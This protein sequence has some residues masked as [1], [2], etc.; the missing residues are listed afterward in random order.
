MDATRDYHIKWSQKENTIPYHSSMES[1]IQHQWTCLQNKNRLTDI[2]IELVVARAACCAWRP[3]PS[4]GS[5]GCRLD[6]AL[7]PGWLLLL[8]DRLCLVLTAARK[9]EAKCSPDP[10]PTSLKSALISPTCRQS[11][12]CAE[13]L[14]SW[15]TGPQPAGTRDW[16]PF[17]IECSEQP[18]GPA[19]SAG[20]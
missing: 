15:R 9:P 14:P 18:F 17:G 16:A 1:K 10:R 11:R 3:A 2:E 13:I 8:R 5:A 19:W 7:H 4:S 12:K 20:G 6:F